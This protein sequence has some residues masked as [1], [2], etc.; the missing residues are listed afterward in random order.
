MYRAERNRTVQNVLA[1]DI[2][3]CFEDG[4]VTV[5]VDH[6]NAGYFADPAGVTRGANLKARAAVLFAQGA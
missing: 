5:E 6:G 1:G 2:R 4:E 3:F